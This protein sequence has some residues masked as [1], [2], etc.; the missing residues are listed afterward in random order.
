MVVI[1]D[2]PPHGGSSLDELTP[3]YADDELVLQDPRTRS[4]EPL[5]A[6]AS[7]DALT[8]TSPC[9]HPSS[10]S[11][12]PG[13]LVQTKPTSSS[14]LDTDAS[15]LASLPSTRGSPLNELCFGPSSY[16]VLP[17]LVS[18]PSHSVLFRP[19]LKPGHLPQPFPDS[20]RDVWDGNHVRMPCSSHSLFPVALSSGEKKLLPR[21]DI[22]L[23]ALHR[24]LM[25]SFDLQE[26]ILTYNSRKWNFRSLHLYFSEVCNDAESTEFF[27][28]V[29]PRIIELAVSLPRLVTHAVPLLKKQQSYAITLSQQQIASLLANA[30]LCTFPRRNSMQRNSE[31]SSYPSINFNT[32]FMTSAGYGISAVRANKLKSLFHYFHR[33][34][35]KMPEGTVTFARQ[36]LVDPPQ[37]D[38]SQSRFTK[39]H[40]SSVGTIEDEGHG[41][42]QVHVGTYTCTCMY[43]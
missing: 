38:G 19:R 18:S 21:W 4:S 32:L 15:R 22:I 9:P 24:P 8:P 26:A 35:T 11:P 25:N 7:D 42:L 23:E 20:F 12:S 33:V 27:H 37:W 16:P 6:E 14:A 3:L 29:L 10:P 34:T 28:S 5:F 43:M 2:T 41:M 1:P 17:P 31:Y 30:F 40:V 36:V 39:L 13:A